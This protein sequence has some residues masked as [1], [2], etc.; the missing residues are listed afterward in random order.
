MP[1][2]SWI[3]NAIA[4]V[5]GW[6]HPLTGEQLTGRISA[7]D[8]EDA[9]AY[10]RPNAGA[11]SFIDPEG[12][13][14][15]IL[16]YTEEKGLATFRVLSLDRIVSVD[17]DFGDDTTAVGAGAWIRHKFYNGTYSVEAVVT[18]LDEEGEEATTTVSVS[19]SITDGEDAPE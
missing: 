3:K 5:Y 6:A 12:E 10:Y 1:A 19:A 11:K 2:P 17:W 16:K 7:E 4:T 9:V 13:T 15:T 8:A 18:Y 14:R